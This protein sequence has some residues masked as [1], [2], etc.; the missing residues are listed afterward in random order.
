[1]KLV[2]SPAKSL[3]LESNIPTAEFSELFFKEKSAVLNS[4]LKRK[5][6]S[7]LSTLMHIS[8]KLGQLN[9]DRNQSWHLPFTTTNARQAIYTFSG[10]VYKGLDVYSLSNDKIA[11]MQNTVFILSGLYG[12]LK[13]LDLIQPYRLEMGTKMPVDQHKNLYGFWR[14]SV[15]EMLNS[16]IAD[17]EVF[18]NLASN[19]YF[20]VIDEKSLKVPVI[21]VTFKEF[22]NG[23]FKTIAIFSKLARGLMT[24]YIIDHN[25]KS[26]D[27]LKG[28]NSNGYGFSEQLSSNQELVFT[29]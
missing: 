2:I 16:S 6:P 5:S 13:P 17:D 14:Q 8:D 27:D 18:I 25:A 11:Q 29:R 1:M 24:R 4:L 19:E 20:K 9:Y 21:H 12:I 28:F 7:E 15:T 10:D 3:D 22:K 23:T 26:V